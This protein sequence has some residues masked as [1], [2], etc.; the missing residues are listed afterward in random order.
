LRIPALAFQGEITDPYDPGSFFGPS[1]PVSARSAAVDIDVRPPPAAAG[2]DAWL[3]ARALTLTLDGLDAGQ[4]PRVGEPLNLTLVLRATGLGADAL[5]L[6][7]LP[8]LDGATVYPDKAVDTTGNSG[9]WLLGVRQRAFAVVPERAGT[10]VLPAL[11]VRW[12]NVLTDRAEVAQL[13]ARELTVLPALGAP[14]ATPA[15]GVHAGS[16][17]ASAPASRTPLPPPRSMPWRWIALGSLALWAA[18][19]LSWW[20]LRRRRRAPVAAASQPGDSV[21][22]Q[23]Q[24]FRDAARQSDAAAQ[25]H[26]LLAWAR[27]ERAQIRDLG[28]LAAALA[29]PAQRSAIAAL[30]R[31]RYAPA[32]DDGDRADPALAQAFRRGFGWR[33]DDRAPPPEVPPLYPFK[34]R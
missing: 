20:I 15:T 10:L 29:D 9:P 1:T 3:P 16:D 34:L 17:G 28:D 31:R 2:T 30:Q 26:A 8:A 33:A 22:A 12:W 7:T 11:R 18:S 32:G 14:N 4:P 19:V 6:P 24:A 21:R 27:A 25:V 13:P 5:P 23:R